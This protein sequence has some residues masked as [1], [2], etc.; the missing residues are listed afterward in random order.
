MIVRIATVVIRG[1]ETS[2][3]TNVNKE[4]IACQ[5]VTSLSQEEVQQLPPPPLLLQVLIA[6]IVIEALE[7][8][9][10]SKDT[11]VKVQKVSDHLKGDTNIIN[12]FT[13]HGVGRFVLFI[14]NGNLN[15]DFGEGDS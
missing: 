5:V 8:Q 6:N 4:V 11:S 9:V 13:V 10:T 12:K 1:L 14:S 7:G 2:G 15:S 3:D